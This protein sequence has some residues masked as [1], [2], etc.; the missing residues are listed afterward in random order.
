MM[1]PTIHLNGTAE[2]ELVRQATT[3]LKAVNAAY[4][5][6]VG[7]R[8][9]GRDFYVQGPDAIYKAMAE[10]DEREKCLRKVRDEVEAMA[11]AILTAAGK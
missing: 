2:S 5:A 1:V 9:N 6:V 7:M 8:P 11:V 4:V 10:H 3:A